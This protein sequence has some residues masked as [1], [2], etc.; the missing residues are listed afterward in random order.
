M[1][2]AISKEVVEMAVMEPAFG[3]LY[4]DSSQSKGGGDWE[5][6]GGRWGW[7]VRGRMKH[8]TWG[9]GVGVKMAVGH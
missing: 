8:R 2:K 1:A 7:E 5:V 9:V 4:Q 3:W 6:G